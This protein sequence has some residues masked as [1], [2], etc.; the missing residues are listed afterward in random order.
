MHPRSISNSFSFRFESRVGDRHPAEAV[1]VEVPYEAAG[2]SPT[3][4]DCNGF[5]ALMM[6]VVGI[7]LA[8][9]TEYH[10]AGSA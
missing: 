7:T 4:Y 1:Q 6:N 5:R 2:D 10:R 9:G 8:R 3:R